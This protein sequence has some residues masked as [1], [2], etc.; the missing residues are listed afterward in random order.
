M[1]RNL[2]RG[3]FARSYKLRTLTHLQ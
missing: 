1:R 2:G 3:D